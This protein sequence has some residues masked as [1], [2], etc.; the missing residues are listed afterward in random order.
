MKFT[1]NLAAF[2]LVPI[3]GAVF[4]WWG[5]AAIVDGK[6]LS[7]TIALLFAI[8][9]FC[10]AIQWALMRSAPHPRAEFGSEG[11]TIRPRK[12]FDTLS[13]IWVGAAVLGALLF[14]VLAP[15]GLLDIPVYRS[16]PWLAAF[17]L[18][19]GMPTLWR[20]IAHGG[21]SYVR[22]TPD[23]CEVWNGQWLAMRRAG[24]DD[25][26]QIQDHPLRRNIRG[27][28]L[29][30]LVLPEGRSATLLS[31]AIT[32]DTP[33]LREWVRFYW[34]HPEHRAE[35]TDGR[36]LRRLEVENLTTE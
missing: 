28:E 2:V 10:F 14:A 34:Q 33:A 9:F 21:D 6:I 27:R 1:S 8:A 20:M 22:L 7:G 32:R 23:G 29:I 36:A 25:I 24:W 30:V 4:V 17:I 19:A 31:D 5:I 26:A 16:T 18:S 15:F 3:F 12:L 35:L 11:T 13:L